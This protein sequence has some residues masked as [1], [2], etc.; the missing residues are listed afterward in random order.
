METL[1]AD[2]VAEAVM[3]SV[4][5]GWPHRRE[6]WELLLG[7]SEGW[8]AVDGTGRVVGTAV[9]TPFGATGGAINMVIVAASLRGRGI[10][11]RLFATAL[12]RANGRRLRLTATTDGEPLYRSLGF[13]PFGHIFQRQGTLAAVPE[14]R[15]AENADA[16]DLAAIAS[17]DKAAYGEDRIALLRALSEVG[18]FAVVRRNGTV[19][20]FGC[21]RQFG[22]GG[23]IGPVVAWSTQ[24]AQSLIGHLAAGQEVLSCG[25]TSRRL[26]GWKAGWTAWAS[27]KPTTGWSCGTSCR[28]F[29]RRALRGSWHWRATPWAD[30]MA[31]GSLPAGYGRQEACACA[32]VTGDEGRIGQAR[33]CWRRL[34]LRRS[35]WRTTSESGKPKAK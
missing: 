14:T 11:R 25:S 6:D 34:P 21:F 35:K 27:G 3:L 28:S 18:R 30:G 31:G 32:S 16:G 10:G 8:A 9:F 12:A 4:E 17:L 24:D 23:L 22:R 33:S 19:A 20:A 2:H 13:T 29:P 1:T 7:F 5:A 26:R 15:G